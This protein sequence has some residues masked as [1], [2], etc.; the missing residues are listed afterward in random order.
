MGMEW[1][2]GLGDAAWTSTCCLSMFMSTLHVCVHAHVYAVC[3][4]LCCTVRCVSASILHVHVNAAVHVRAARTWTCSTDMDLHHGRGDA[5]WTSVC[6][7][8][9][10]CKSCVYMS[11]LHIH[12][13]IHVPIHAAC[14][15]HVRANASIDVAVQPRHGR[16]A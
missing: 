7:L 8:F 16:S 11:I 10:S 3:T 14:R 15:A 13:M 1:Q 5:A 2:H 4:G 6:C 9:M 12:A